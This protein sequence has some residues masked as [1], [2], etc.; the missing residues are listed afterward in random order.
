ME[1]IQVEIKNANALTILEGM[2][3]AQIIRLLKRKKQTG[4][5]LASFK[6][7]LNSEKAIEMAKQI[8]QQREE[9]NSTSI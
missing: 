5:N 7:I 8:D 3:K 9:W 6:G 1:I 2:E 4:S